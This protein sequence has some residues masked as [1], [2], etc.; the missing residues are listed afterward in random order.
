[1]A[2]N[3]AAPINMVRAVLPHMLAAK[4]GRIISVTSGLGTMARAGHLLYRSP[5]A[6][7]ESAMAVLAAELEGTGV[8]SHVLVPGGT[9]NTA[10]VGDHT[11]DPEKCCNRRSWCRHCCGYC[12]SK[13]QR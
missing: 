5:K 6:T 12:R 3:G 4:R 11:R 10:L 8:T 1:M 13:R 2:L 7:V 9:T